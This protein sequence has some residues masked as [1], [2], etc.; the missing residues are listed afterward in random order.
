MN[1]HLSSL[2]VGYLKQAKEMIL[3]LVGEPESLCE[4]TYG[5]IG[6]LKGSYITEKPTLALVMTSQACIPAQLH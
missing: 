2:R 4:V 1:K 6:D 3:W 5:N